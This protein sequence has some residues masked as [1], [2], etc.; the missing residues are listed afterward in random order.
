MSEKQKAILIR[1][2]H[3]NREQHRTSVPEY[4]PEHERLNRTPDVA[5]V[6]EDFKYAKNHPIAVGKPKINTPG[7][8]HRGILT[9]RQPRFPKQQAVASGHNEELSWLPQEVPNHLSD[10]NEEVINYDDIPQPPRVAPMPDLEQLAA[11]A[12][13]YPDPE[14][15][16]V[17]EPN[18][19]SIDDISPG[20][21]FVVV[22]DA[23][24]A[25]APELEPIEE[26]IESMVFNSN[27]TISLDDIVV[28]RKMDLRVGVNVK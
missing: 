23:I 15:E 22:M 24:V 25:E 2:K 9:P 21:Y 27:N 5:E 10:P 18:R 28:L 16:P 11:H 19:V 26:F 6:S 17:P 13:S 14:P 7:I 12:E 3:R 4:Y 20:N 1:N 8:D